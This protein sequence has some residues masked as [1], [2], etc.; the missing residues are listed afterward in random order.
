MSFFRKKFVVFLRVLRVSLGFIV[1]LACPG[2][3]LPRGLS[4]RIVFIAAHRD[5]VFSFGYSFSMCFGVLFGVLLCFTGISTGV[6]TGVGCVLP[7]S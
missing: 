7:V 6:R 3:C 1:S 4:D 5:C 2:S